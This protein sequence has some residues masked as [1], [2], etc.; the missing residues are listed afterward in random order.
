MTKPITFLKEVLTLLKTP[1]RNILVGTAVLATMTLIISIPT[2]LLV[3]YT[4]ATIIILC[5]LFFLA[6]AHNIGRDF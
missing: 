3:N 6:L 1:I 2:Y 4:K 5:S